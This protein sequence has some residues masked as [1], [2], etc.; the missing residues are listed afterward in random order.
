MALQ[1]TKLG[2]IAYVGSTAAS[3]YAN[4]ASTKTFVRGVVLFNGGVTSELVKLYLVPDVASAVGT[5]A[6]GNQFAELTLEP[7]ETLLLEFPY[8]LVLTDVNDTL[9]ASTTT[10]STVTVVVNGDKDA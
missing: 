8:A 7:K 4:P 9:Q 10:A 1:R 3:I 6:A 2:D 5:A